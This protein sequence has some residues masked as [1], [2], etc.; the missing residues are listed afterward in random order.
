MYPTNVQLNSSA[1]LT[2]NLLDIYLNAIGSTWLIDDLFLF[3][4]TSFAFAG[5]LSNALSFYIF[6]RHKEFRTISLFTYYR[7]YTLNSCMNLFILLFSFCSFSPRFVPSGLSRVGHIYRCLI[8]NYMCTSLLFHRHIVSIFIML[9]R[10]SLFAASRKLSSFV[11]YRPQMLCTVAFVACCL[12]NAPLFFQFDVFNANYSITY[13]LSEIRAN[14][15]Q[16]IVYCRKNTFFDSQKGQAI[17]IGLFLLRDLFTFVTELLISAISLVYFK[18]Y[19]RRQVSHSRF[20]LKNNKVI[21][22]EQSRSNAQLTNSRSYT[23]K[24][25]SQRLTKMTFLFGIVSIFCHLIVFAAS[26]FTTI[27]TEPATTLKLILASM[28][29][30]SLRGATN[31]F[32]FYFFNSHFKNK[33]SEIFAF[34]SIFKCKYLFS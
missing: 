5:V 23:E 9:D 19:F 3:V 33:I 17:L 27:Y 14:Q 4:L 10:L 13:I 26:I 11:S 34:K 24:K 20:R 2:R 21:T 1:N 18:A 12:I 32:F 28:L 15:T 6:A 22:S 7:C 30:V 16:M 31:F 29:I 25:F 8:F